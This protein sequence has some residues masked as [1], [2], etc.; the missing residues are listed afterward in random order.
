M[1]KQDCV[2]CKIAKKEI[3]SGIIAETNNFLAFLDI[4]PKAE[5]H[6][7]IIPKKHYVTLLDIPSNLG[8]EIL[9]ITK[10][11]ASKL[12]DEKKGDGFNIVM[13]NLHPAGQ[14][15]MHAHL[16]VIPRKEKDKVKTL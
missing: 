10:V 1:K 7:L 11:V 9:K 8:E 12:L 2:F 13:N 3:R 5:G 4:E 15:V 16:H 14:I 6:T